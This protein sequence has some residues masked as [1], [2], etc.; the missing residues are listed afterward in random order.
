M[1]FDSSDRYRL[2]SR[3]FSLNGPKIRTA[4]SQE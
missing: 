4:H 2:L 1:R 3:T